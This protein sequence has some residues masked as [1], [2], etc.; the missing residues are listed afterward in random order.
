MVLD[1][2]DVVEV[3]IKSKVKLVLL[4]MMVKLGVFV[5]ILYDD[6]VVIVVGENGLVML[7]VNEGYFGGMFIL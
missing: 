1:V 5:I 4:I 3:D 7:M 2:I 6:L